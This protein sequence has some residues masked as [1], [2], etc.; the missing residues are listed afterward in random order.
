MLTLKVDGLLNRKYSCK[1]D[2]QSFIMMG[3]QWNLSI[4]IYFIRLKQAEYVQ[5]KVDQL[6]F[7]LM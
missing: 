5:T 4:V 7:K 3:Y 6:E 1:N 2:W